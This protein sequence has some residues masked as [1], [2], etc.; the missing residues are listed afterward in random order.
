[1]S[2]SRGGASEVGLRCAPTSLSSSH[3]NSLFVTQVPTGI[4]TKTKGLLVQRQRAVA[5]LRASTEEQTGSY[6]AQEA[7]IAAWADENNIEIVEFCIDR[8]ISGTADLNDRPQLV[9]AIELTKRLS[10]PWL[11][12]QRRDRLARDALTAAH[13]EY[14][15]RRNGARVIST[16]EGAA[17]LTPEREL[18]TAVINA[19]AQ[20]EVSLL[21]ERTKAGLRAAVARGVKLGRPRGPRPYLTRD[22]I[23]T[24]ALIHEH[25]TQGTG[26]TDISAIL[27]RENRPCA[28]KGGWTRSHVQLIA[29]HFQDIDGLGPAALAGD[30]RACLALCGDPRASKAER[31]VYAA[32]SDAMKKYHAK[33]R[34]GEWS[35][36]MK[37]RRAAFKAKA[38]A[39]AEAAEA[40][41]AAEKVAREKFLAR[42]QDLK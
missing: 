37:D 31:A 18:T 33:V 4:R 14:L 39:A 24:L 17:P 21:R 32:G 12:V 2:L 6:E 42:Q 38:K 35:T 26:L 27:D 5:Y 15:V 23:V 1:M 11:V 10:L 34:R 30:L 19:V 9:V 36:E 29:D 8:A 25:L 22:G 7:D 41:K 13:I 40:R 16:T 28:S 3:K 20:F